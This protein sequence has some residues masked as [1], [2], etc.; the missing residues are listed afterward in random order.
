MDGLIFE[1]DDLAYGLSLGATGHHE[2]RL[3][4]FKWE[5]QLY[6]TTFRGLDMAT[7]HTGMVSF[8]GVF[9]DVIIDG[10]TANHAYLHN[11]DIFDEFQFGIDDKIRGYKANMIIPQIADNLTQSNTYV[12]PMTCP[13]CGGPLAAKTSPGGTRQLFCENAGCPAKLVRKFVHFCSKTRMEIEGFAGRTLETF[14]QH[15]WIKNFD[16][17]YELER[18]RDDIIAAPEFGAKSYE[19]LQKAVDKRH[20]CTLSQFIA[21]VGIPEVGRHADRR[22]DPTENP[23]KR[24][25]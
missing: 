23:A 15:G 6:E 18:H 4:A 16:D 11:L 24:V 17:I 9:D 20:V 8:T 7:I 10:T 1:F 21:A 14:V 25:A 13:C 2:N 3:M 22:A 12:L 5:N 19:R